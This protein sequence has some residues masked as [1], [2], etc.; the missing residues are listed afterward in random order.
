MYASLPG[1][2]DAWHL[3]LFEQPAPERIFAV[4]TDL[5]LNYA[6]QAKK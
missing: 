3:G 6:D 2:S 1:I 5:L 4:L